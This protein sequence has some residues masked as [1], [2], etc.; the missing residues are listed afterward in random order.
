MWTTCWT[1]RR[2]CQ[3]RAVPLSLHNIPKHRTRWRSQLHLA[4]RSSS[5]D[6]HPLQSQAPKST[7]R[8]RPRLWAARPHRPTTRTTRS[9]STRTCRSGRQSAP[10][11]EEQRAGRTIRRR[12]RASRRRAIPTDPQQPILWRSPFPSSMFSQNTRRISST[13]LYRCFAPYSC[14]QF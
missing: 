3:C 1:R 12:G 10:I 4:P 9:F 8:A 2:T 6:P 11:A 14:N 13:S 7:T 5:L